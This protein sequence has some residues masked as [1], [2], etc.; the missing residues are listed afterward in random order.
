[1]T[2]KINFNQIKGSV[3]NIFDYLTAAQIA[4]VQAKSYASATD[5]GAEINAALT[6]ARDGG[7][8]TGRKTVFF[9]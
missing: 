9:P 2:T 4:A 1:M 5:V 8:G 3:I 7:A 6:A